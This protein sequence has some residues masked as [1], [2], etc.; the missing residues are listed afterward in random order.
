M[1]SQLL[2]ICIIDLRQIFQA[3][4]GL[5]LKSRLLRDPSDLCGLYSL[6]FG[7]ASACVGFLT[8]HVEKLVSTK[9]PADTT[10]TVKCLRR[11]IFYLLN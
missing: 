3:G 1:K 6:H 4:T 9:R 10:E 7:V 11:I 8:L 5:R 2:F